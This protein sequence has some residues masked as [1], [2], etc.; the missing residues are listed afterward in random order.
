MRL[1]HLGHS[2]LLVEVDGARLLLDPGSF[3]HGF[4]E[5]TDLDAVIITHQHAD[6]VDVQRLPML[7]EANGRAL[8]VAEPETA[9]ELTGAGIEARPLHAGDELTVA[10]GRVRAAG[11]RHPVVPPRPPPG[12]N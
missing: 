4:E 12:G 5:L 1:T 2:C 10:G 11:G 7:L 6:H 3:S 8:L 9:A